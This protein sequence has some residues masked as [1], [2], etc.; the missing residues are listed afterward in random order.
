[1]TPVQKSLLAFGIGL[2]AVFLL[3]GVYLM[4][5]IEPA[6]AQDHTVRMMARANHVYILFVSL[7][8]MLAAPVDTRTAARWL[9]ISVG[10][11]QASLVASALNLVAAFFQE[12]GS[13]G[14]PRTLTLAGCVTA[15]AGVA[16]VS[17]RAFAVTRPS[18]R[19]F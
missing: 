19:S 2:F 17:L 1:M 5:V 16:L 3:T 14:S 18:R 12:H 9:R 7:L 4:K 11:G 10:A 8:I 6:H 13:F 15:L